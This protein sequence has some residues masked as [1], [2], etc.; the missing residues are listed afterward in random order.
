[1]IGAPDI[2]KRLDEVIKNLNGHHDAVAVRADFFRNANHAASGVA[3]EVEEKGLAI[4]DDFFCAN[5]IVFHFY[6]QELLFYAPLVSILSWN[7]R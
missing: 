6:M 4:R 7:E 5:D 1:M 2:L 3:L